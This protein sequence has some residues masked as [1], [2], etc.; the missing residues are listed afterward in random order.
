MDITLLRSAIFVTSL[1]NKNIQNQQQG[2]SKIQLLAN[3]E[4]GVLKKRCQNFGICRIHLH[5]SLPPR[6][7]PRLKPSCIAV[8]I[9]SKKHLEITFL[10]DYLNKKN[11]DKY[12][13]SG[14][15]Q[16]DEDV[17]LA[18]VIKESQEAIEGVISAGK[19]PLKE[20][21]NTYNVLFDL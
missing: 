18:E 19:Y 17:V 13:K 20:S 3:V 2:L 16:I 4:F 9:L 1:R 21:S 5:G 10:K 15:F 7:T 6:D 11:D 12:F 14:F 8:L